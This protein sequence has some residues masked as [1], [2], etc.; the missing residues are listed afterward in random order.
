MSKH[1]AA[2]PGREFKA[3]ESKGEVQARKWL[4]REFFK[5]EM[6]SR[7]KIEHKS[8]HDFWVL[9]FYITLT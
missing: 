3:E 9:V 7:V 6:E 5:R 8:L 1:N 4:P 2:K